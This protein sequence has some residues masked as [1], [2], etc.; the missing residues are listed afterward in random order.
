MTPALLARTLEQFL[1][2]SRHGVVVE[3]G[4]IVFDLDSARFSISADRGRCLLH[5]WSAERNL[6]RE[7][8]DAE[9]KKDTLRLAAR[10]FAQSRPHVLQ[11]CRER[12]RRT[13]AARKTARSYYSKVLERVIE[14][15]FPDWTVASLWAG[16]LRMATS[17]ISM[18]GS[19]RSLHACERRG[20][21]CQRSAA[22]PTAR[23]AHLTPGKDCS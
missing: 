20:R 8:V 7:V 12:D 23:S 6:V 19:A 1:V 9:L 17:M 21:R 10:K 11:I 13:P 14:R 3:A 15:E 22:S 16:P 18:A 4:E 2:E 5:M